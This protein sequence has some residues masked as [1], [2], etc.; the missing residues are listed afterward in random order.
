MTIAVE[1][2]DGASAG[3]AAIRNKLVDLHWKLLGVQVTPDSP[4]VNEAFN[5][6]FE[7]WSNKRRW[8]R[9][10]FDDTGF[11]CHSG[12]DYGYY[13][14]LVDDP[15]EYARWGDF[16]SEWNWDN[17]NNLYHETDMNDPA[18][19]VRAWVITLAW[20]MTDF[21]YLYF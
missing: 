19:A 9:Q 4:D 20:L 1:S 15:W 16:P 18:Y 10:Y 7:V 8:E 21:R 2:D 6:F 12:D 3:A 17:V 14:G 5:L 11:R 13:E